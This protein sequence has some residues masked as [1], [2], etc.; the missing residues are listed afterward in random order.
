M[1]VHVDDVCWWLHIWLYWSSYQSITA[2]RGTHESPNQPYQTALPSQSF[3]NWSL[4]VT[5]DMNLSLCVCVC[6]IDSIASFVWVHT[7][8]QPINRWRR[9]GQV[10]SNKAWSQ[11]ALPTQSFYNQSQ[12]VTGDIS[13]LL[14][15]C[16][17]LDNW[18]YL[19]QHQLINKSLGNNLPTK[20]NENR[21][22]SKLY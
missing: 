5:G 4:P 6:V 17:W 11:R 19:I 8:Q 16:W 7:N 18:L 13:L 10:N 21:I 3:R 12:I 22:P 9:T 20:I 1:F 15:V 2:E 14:C